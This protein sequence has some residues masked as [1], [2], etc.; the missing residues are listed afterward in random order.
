MREEDDSARILRHGE[1][2]G[3]EVLT[4]ANA[5]RQDRNGLVR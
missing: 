4:S 5:H 2:R 3:D 1:I